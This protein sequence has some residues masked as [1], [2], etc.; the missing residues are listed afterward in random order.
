[1][2]WFKKVEVVVGRLA[3]GFLYSFL[4][5][6]VAG[7]TVYLLSPTISNAGLQF[8]SITIGWGVGMLLVLAASTLLMG[9]KHTTI[10]ALVAATI[11][12]TFGAILASFLVI[13]VAETVLTAS[14]M[15]FAIA[16]LG[17][18]IV[19]ALLGGWLFKRYFCSEDLPTQ[20]EAQPNETG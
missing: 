6:A 18:G 1:M 13:A 20:N 12:C 9:R 17:G 19:M 2:N 8:V 10:I 16:L 15:T 14:L 4:F 3:Y 11:G 7:L 5:A